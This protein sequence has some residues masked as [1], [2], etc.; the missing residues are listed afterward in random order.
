MLVFYILCAGN[1]RGGLNILE[2]VLNSTR[3]LWS[4]GI[5]QDQWSAGCEID[6]SLR[7]YIIFSQS[8]SP[9]NSVTTGKARYLGVYT[10]G[11]NKGTIFPSPDCWLRRHPVR[12]A[13]SFVRSCYS[14]FWF[15]LQKICRISKIG[16]KLWSRGCLQRYD[17]KTRH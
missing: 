16:G 6:P 3:R 5:G 9:E 12:V 7:N 17:Q 8:K 4:R 11:P 13:E 10:P 14:V 2:F 15:C 1:V